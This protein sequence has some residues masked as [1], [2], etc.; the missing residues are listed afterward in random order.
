MTLENYQLVERTKALYGHMTTVLVGS[1][2]V[3]VLTVL[4]LWPVVSKIQLL[5]WFA[6]MMISM[7]LR[8]WSVLRYKATVIFEE[9]AKKWTN[10]VIFWSSLS[11]AGWGVVLI[12]F[13]VPDEH[14]YLVFIVGVY[15]GFVSSSV[16]SLAIHFPAYLAFTVPISVLFLL[17]CIVFGV[18]GQGAVFYLTGVIVVVFWSV[19]TSFAMKAHA[20][21]DRTTRLIFERNELMSEVVEQKEAA[22]SA[23]LAKNQFLASASHD[24]RQ[25]LHALGLFV[26]ALR[27]MN[28]HDEAQEVAGKIEQST[29]ALNGLLNGLLDISRLDASAVE[30]RPQHI[31]IKP[32]LETIFLEYK[33]VAEDQ[34]SEMILNVDDD[35]LVFSDELLLQRIIRNLVDNAVK[36]TNNGVIQITVAFDQDQQSFPVELVI[37][38]TGF[39]VPEDQQKNIF[40]EFT[41]LHNPERNRQKG[42][43]LGLAIVRR[44]CKLMD[45]RLKM[46]STTGVGTA[47]TIR[48]QAGD[49]QFFSESFEDGVTQELSEMTIQDSLIS[50]SDKVVLV[51]DDDVDI[52]QATQ[53]LLKHWQTKAVVAMDP[54]QAINIL[55]N[56][57]LVPDLIMADFRLRGSLNGIDAISQIRDEFNADIHAILITGDTSP[58]R[59]RLA[60]SAG[61]PILHKP[62]EPKVLNDT[63]TELLSY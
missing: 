26:S 53:R 17:T 46:R 55:N 42:L 57:D 62:V 1:F 63:I 32:L 45:L 8:A 10:T 60:H 13:S 3:A 54:E 24:L 6:V 11:G 38:D 36:F 44:L 61:L 18:D 39:G 50:L 15:C 12:F 2:A 25:P 30:Y 34:G 58:D 41:Q 40:S 4:V 35:V 27:D 19:M 28:I 33:T 37:S 21:F 43:G 59:L 48:L 22:E 23:V 14:I 20:G 47:F 51:I 9:N 16:S 7:L 52:L 31:A 49:S 56:R 29:L 5:T